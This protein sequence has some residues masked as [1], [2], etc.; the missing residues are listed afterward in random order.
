M[1]IQPLCGRMVRLVKIS[2]LRSSCL[3]VQ[4][5]QR[6]QQII[7]VIIG[8]HSPVL[9]AVNQS[10]VPLRRHHRV[11]SAL[12]VLPQFPVLGRSSVSSAIRL[13]TQ[14]RSRNQPP[15]PLGCCFTE[16][17]RVHSAVLPVVDRSVYNGK[18]IVLHIGIS[19]NRM[20]LFRPGLHPIPFPHRF[21]R[22]CCTASWS[23][24]DSTAPGMGRTV[25][26]SLPYWV[27]SVESSPSTI[28]GCCSKIAVQRDTILSLVQM[29]PLR[30]HSNH[31]LSLL[32]KQNV[33][34][35]AA[36]RRWQG[37]HC[38]ADEWS[39]A[40]P[41]AGRRYFRTSVLLLSMVYRLVTKATTPP[42]R[43]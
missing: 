9:L 16:L 1:G 24:W 20:R 41:P 13:R 39:P 40:T 32:Q 3:L 4:N 14:S 17:R 12:T 25:H 27:L 2:A 37:M 23:C 11:G 7:A 15:N 38:S 35:Y 10:K 8:K 21:R 18:A 22:I 36:F 42:G 5:F 31:A 30:F 34:H 28:S 33:R 6:T 19:G 43:T 26:S 29:H